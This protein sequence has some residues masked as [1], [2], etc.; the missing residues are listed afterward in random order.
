MDEKYKNN[1]AKVGGGTK[2]GDVSFNG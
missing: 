2:S 1:V